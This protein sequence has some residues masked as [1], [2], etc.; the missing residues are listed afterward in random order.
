MGFG[1]GGVGVRVR[2]W[3]GVPDV[4]WGHV[5]LVIEAGLN[6]YDIHA[7]IA[8]IEAAGGV[9]T[10]WSGASAACGGRVIAAANQELHEKAV[11]ILSNF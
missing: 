5:D 8:V 3:C 6:A 9:V 11:K 1:P 7:P 4:G 2:Q 10:D